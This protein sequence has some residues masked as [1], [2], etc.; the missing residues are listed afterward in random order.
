MLRKSNNFDS[1][2]EVIRAEHRMNTLCKRERRKRKYTKVAE[3][4]WNGGKKEVVKKRKEKCI[5]T[6]KK[7]A[8]IEMENNEMATCILAKQ[9][10]NVQ[11]RKGAKKAKKTKKI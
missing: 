2:A 10:R 7:D 11:R 4:F 5:S 9:P 6:Q 3:E 1:P 8:T